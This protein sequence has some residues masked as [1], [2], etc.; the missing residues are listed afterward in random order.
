LRLKSVY[1]FKELAKMLEEPLICCFSH[2]S[3]CL[4]WWQIW[5]TIVI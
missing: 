3:N 5:S 2:R 1:I 4:A